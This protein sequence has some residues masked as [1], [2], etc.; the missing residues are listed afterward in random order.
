MKNLQELE[1]G[2]IDKLKANLGQKEEYEVKT[3]GMKGRS[4]D[5]ELGSNRPVSSPIDP[6]HQN[7]LGVAKD[8]LPYHY[9]EMDPHHNAEIN[10]FLES[11][12]LTEEF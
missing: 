3:Y 7:F 1:N 10:S 9:D 12:E 5:L 4:Q 6:T 11:V 2:S 8:L